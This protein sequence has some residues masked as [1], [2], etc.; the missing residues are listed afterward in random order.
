METKGNGREGKDTAE[1]ERTGE[2]DRRRRKRKEEEG[3]RNK[4]KDMGG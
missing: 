4:V 2:E 1:K 3:R